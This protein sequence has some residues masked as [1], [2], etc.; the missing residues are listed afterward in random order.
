MKPQQ[1][2]LLHRR[3]ISSESTADESKHLLHGKRQRTQLNIK[4]LTEDLTKLFELMVR[5]FSANG[6]QPLRHEALPQ[7]LTDHVIGNQTQDA[8][9]SFLQLRHRAA[10]LIPV[11]SHPGKL[12]RFRQKAH[13]HDVKAHVTHRLQPLGDKLRLELL[14][15]AAHLIVHHVGGGVEPLEDHADQPRQ[16]LGGCVL[17]RRAQTHQEPDAELTEQSLVMLVVLFVVKLQVVQGM[18]G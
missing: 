5:N 3:W 16:A 12:H 14:H 9:Q 15:Q 4:H 10:R 8:I 6:L 11:S 1:C 2:L 18:M 7:R 17:A 13:D